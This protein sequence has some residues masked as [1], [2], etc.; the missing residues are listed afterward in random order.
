MQLTI[1]AIRSGHDPVGRLPPAAFH[2]WLDT[3]LICPKCDATYNLVCD[4]DQAIG[5]HFE[6][7]S[8][9]LI[10]LLKKA[11]FMGHGDGHWVVHF[12]T[13]GVVVKS[14]GEPP[15]KPKKQLRVQ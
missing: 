7:E 1:A 3:P 2:R 5:R 4:Y 6:A 10:Q 13:S 14:F 8:R 11:I 15:V 9:R 12:E